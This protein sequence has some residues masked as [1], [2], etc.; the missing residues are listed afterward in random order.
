[1]YTLKLYLL[2]STEFNYIL[3]SLKK[4]NIAVVNNVKLL[5]GWP[6]SKNKGSGESHPPLLI[7]C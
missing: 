4:W 7:N 3:T 1:M 5:F 2:Q 6:A